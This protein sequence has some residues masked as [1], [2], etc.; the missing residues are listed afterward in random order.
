[1]TFLSRFTE[2]LR[3]QG[4]AITLIK[5]RS[6]AMDHWFDLRYGMDTCSWSDLAELRI[7]SENK[8]KGYGYRPARLLPLRR[9]LREIVPLLP[10]ER[11]LVD[12]GSGK[13]RVLMVASEFGFKEVR[14]VEF[15]PEL[16]EIARRN[17]VQFQ[18]ASGCKARFRIIE[19]D[20]TKYPIQDDENV[21]VFYNPFDGAILSKVL[22]NIRTSLKQQ[23]R[24][25][26][27]VYYNPRWSDVFDGF[28]EFRVARQ[29]EFWGFKFVIYSSEA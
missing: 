5:L 24:K 29:L 2:S 1:M 13:G 7:S 22:E 11:V 3:S 6:V 20:A 27:I 25:I 17:V 15:S 28:P 19:Q 14:G 10:A 8:E 4:P 12:V 18:K 23:P 16:C 9:M 21:F 26:V